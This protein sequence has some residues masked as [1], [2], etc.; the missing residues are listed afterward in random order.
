MSGTRKVAALSGAMLVMLVSACGGSAK[1]DSATAADATCTPDR[2][3]GTVTVGTYS[4]PRGLD[5]VGQPGNAATGGT[6]VSALFDTLIDWNA[7]KQTYEPRVAE[8]LLPDPQ[9]IQWT[10][11]LRDG[12]TF[13]NGDPLTANDV[14]ASIARHQSREN[15]Q[16]SR[17]E[18]ALI[19]AVDVV[20]AKT[21]R[22]TLDGPYPDFPHVLATD[23]G[24]ITNPRLV[25]QRG[26]DG[27]AR[28]PTGGGVGPYELERYAPG[29]EIVLKAKPNYWG[30]PVCV[31]ALRFVR[32]SGASATYEALANGELDVAFL[33]EPQVIAEAR[34]AGYRDL[35]TLINYG[36]SVIM[37]AAPGRV[38]SDQ[39]IRRA[40]VA[41]IDPQ[42][43]NQR[44]FNGSALA[45]SAL[46]HPQTPGLY[47][48]E[49][50]PEHD[51]AT[52][53][54][55][56]EQAKAGGWDGTIGLVADST[57]TRINE[58]IAVKAQL[59]S[60]GFNV[61]LENSL[62]LQDVIKRVVVDRNY[63][64]ALWG[65]Q[66]FSE[67]TW[68]TLSRQLTGAAESNYYG[69]HDP[70][71]D[72]VLGELRAAATV[73]EK[74]AALGRLQVL[75]TGDPFAANLA[76]FEEANVFSDRV[77]GLRLSRGS[78]IRFD[79][80]FVSSGS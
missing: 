2:I 57:P 44:V 34:Q 68:A 63:D 67:G 50:G 37:N 29:E 30:G 80:A 75:L 59:E 58:A 17:G 56:V 47:G 15:T 33:R 77:G 64:L 78:I 28:N 65:P 21:V 27:F 7:E 16:A 35:S 48:G 11:K 72:R 52:A 25:E 19:S 66:V 4:E 55:L 54:R 14:K 9:H 12:V 74:K 8:S 53:R 49:Q 20:D 5:P 60:V 51:A 62:P 26:A 71:V 76:A 36:E 18:A 73:E 23:V 39:A 31:Q 42:A 79:K 46:V 32:L 13:G 10:L 61:R 69:Y 22:F 38:T 24:M 45:T 41:S 6:E 43:I 1:T 3:G 40:V 70:Q